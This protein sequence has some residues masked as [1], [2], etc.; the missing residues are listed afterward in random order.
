MATFL[1]RQVEAV[2]VAG[3]SPPT[4]GSV[5]SVVRVVRRGKVRVTVVRA[6]IHTIWMESD[7]R[8]S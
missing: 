8:D 1:Q 4:T 6:P 2:D 3:L 7:T 5:A